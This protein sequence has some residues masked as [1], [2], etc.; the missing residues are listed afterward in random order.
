MLWG[1]EMPFDLVLHYQAGVATRSQAHKAGLSDHAIAHRVASGRWQRLYEG[2]YATFS[3]PV[4]R[5]A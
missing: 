1:M 4:P 5:Q 3:G 2:V